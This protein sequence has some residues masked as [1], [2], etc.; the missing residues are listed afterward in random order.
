VDLV[1]REQAQF[2]YRLVDEKGQ[3]DE[4]TF[5]VKDEVMLE[6]PYGDVKALEVARI[7]ENSDRETLYWFAPEHDYLL[8]KMTQIE[9]G[10]EVATLLL[11]T[12]D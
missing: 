8:V 2:E 9:E 1:D 4:Q 12:L 5:Q 11:K 6:L 10:D 3:E 7:R